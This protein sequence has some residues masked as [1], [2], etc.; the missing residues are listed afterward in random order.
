MANNVP[1]QGDPE[2]AAML[3]LL[4]SSPGPVVGTTSITPAAFAEIPGGGSNAVE[5]LK[6][7]QG[8]TVNLAA[9]LSQPHGRAHNLSAIRSALEGG[10]SNAEAIWSVLHSPPGLNGLQGL[11]PSNPLLGMG[12]VSM[13]QQG[14]SPYKA[15]P[16]QAHPLPS[17]KTLSRLELTFTPATHVSSLP[18][19]QKWT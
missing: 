17:P 1:T 8:A 13:P 7:L 2:L 5:L 9:I 10:A 4:L 19:C 3:A 15:P 14:A 11:G 18:A 6:G 16:H 12:L